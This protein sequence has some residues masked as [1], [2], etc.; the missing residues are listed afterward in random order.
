[1]K[2]SRKTRSGHLC[3]LD[4]ISSKSEK[5]KLATEKLWYSCSVRWTVVKANASAKAAVAY[6]PKN[7]AESNM[8]FD[9]I[10]MHTDELEA[11]FTYEPRHCDNNSEYTQR[12]WLSIHIACCNAQRF[13]AV[14]LSQRPYLYLSAM[15]R[16]LTFSIRF[17]SMHS[18]VHGH[19]H[20]L[21]EF[22]GNALS[23]FHFEVHKNKYFHEFNWNVYMIKMPGWW[24]FFN[25]TKK[26]SFCYSKNWPP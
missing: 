8:P 23:C 11:I 12:D 17:Y 10:H 16:Y 5:K 20:I 7:S 3:V 13:S 24:S 2:I 9:Q 14:S 1:M 21:T 25:D 15:S 19:V 4:I 26:K 18:S 6:H 22:V